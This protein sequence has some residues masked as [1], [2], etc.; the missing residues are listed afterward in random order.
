MQSTIIISAILLL[1]IFFAIRSAVNRARHG[2]ACCGTRDAPEKKV[3]VNDKN[4]A[5]YPFSCTVYIDGMHCSN[6]SRHVENAFNSQ[7]GL[8]AKVNLE[9]KCAFVLSKKAI[10]S[11]NMKEIVRNAGYTVDDVKDI[12]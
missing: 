9:K 5:N 3:K 1:I 2:S 7:E 4:K 8:W 6:C 12:V 10:D 11:E